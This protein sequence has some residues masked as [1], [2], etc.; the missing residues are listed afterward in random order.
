MAH[1][2][3]AAGSGDGLLAS[4][5]AALAEVAAGDAAAAGRAV[6]EL[7]HHNLHTLSVSSELPTHERCAC[8]QACIVLI[9]I[10]RLAAC[11]VVDA[12]LNR[13]LVADASASWDHAAEPRA[14]YLC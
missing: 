4:V 3:L 1:F 5:N 2:R 12:V 13:R 11:V 8:G 9:A 6:D 7:Q 10:L 14:R